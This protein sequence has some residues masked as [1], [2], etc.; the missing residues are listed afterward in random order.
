MKKVWIYLE[1][2]TFLEANSFGASNTVVGEIV[3]NVSMSGYQEI[4]SD[5]SYA[6]QFVTFTM[7]EIGN[8]GVNP[9]D[10][11]S[12][13]AHA[14][15]M[16]VRK[17][18]DRYSNFRAEDS[19]ANFLIE[20]N[21]MGICD[22]DTRYITKMLRAEGAMMMIASTEISDKEELKKEEK[23]Y[24][25]VIAYCR[26]CSLT[27]LKFIVNPEIMF[28]NYLYIPSASQTRL[29]NF[30]GLLNDAR[31]RITINLI[32]T[33]LKPRLQQAKSKFV[34]LPQFY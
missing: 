10:M 4:M 28:K 27:Q 21:V 23:E 8:V 25:L 26:S 1:N 18:Q 12:C 5:P 14:K 30:K 31:K 7:P 6:G 24:P 34:S 29:E 16:I 32:Q 22:I 33:L 11:E 3:F 19:L 13:S 17:Y 20:Q 2:G 9:Q 15:G